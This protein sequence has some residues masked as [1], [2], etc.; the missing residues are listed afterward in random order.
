MLRKLDPPRLP[1]TPRV[2]LPCHVCCG[3]GSVT[4][5]VRI[6]AES[7]EYTSVFFQFSNFSLSI[8]NVSHASGSHHSHY[9]LCE[10]YSLKLDNVNNIVSASCSINSG[11]LLAD[12]GFFFFSFT[13]FLIFNSRSFSPVFETPRF[14]HQQSSCLL[15]SSR[16]L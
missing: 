11:L 13:S 16:R 8:M 12:T 10:W 5:P 4:W 7:S 2:P 1:I 3:S 14:F 6:H 15:L 9:F